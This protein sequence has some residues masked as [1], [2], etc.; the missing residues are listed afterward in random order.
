MLSRTADNDCNTA[1][2]NVYAPYSGPVDPHLERLVDREYTLHRSRLVDY[3]IQYAEL[4]G[5]LGDIG[6]PG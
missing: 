4:E 5:L 3:W 1:S 2:Y 6:P